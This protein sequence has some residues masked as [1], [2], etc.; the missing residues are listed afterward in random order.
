MIIPAGIAAILCIYTGVLM[1]VTP[2]RN[3]DLRRV[4]PT[5]KDWGLFLAP[6]IVGSY[7]LV[8]GFDFG[9]VFWNTWKFNKLVIPLIAI[10]A[11]GLVSTL[12][13]FNLWVFP[14]MDAW[15]TAYGADDMQHLFKTRKE[16]D[17]QADE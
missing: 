5:V 2:L 8:L 11:G 7:M 10:I 12:L 13:V 9:A 17:D 16:Q 6:M 15:I 14:V 1:V 4:P 3:G